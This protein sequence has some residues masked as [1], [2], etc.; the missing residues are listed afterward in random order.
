MEIGSAKNLLVQRIGIWTQA[1]AR[2]RAQE[3]VFVKKG[4][5]PN[6]EGFLAWGHPQ[7]EEAK[8]QIGPRSKAEALELSFKAVQ[9]RDMRYLP[10]SDH[11]HQK[12]GRRIIAM[13]TE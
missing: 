9:H 12:R 6:L 10:A 13:D 5:I 11:F 7:F 2:Q 3:R 1:P 4:E 8:R